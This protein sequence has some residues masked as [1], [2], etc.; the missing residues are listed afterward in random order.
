MD[1]ESPRFEGRGQ[2]RGGGNVAFSF[3]AFMPRLGCK[4]LLRICIP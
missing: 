2:A 3:P 4:S 1:N